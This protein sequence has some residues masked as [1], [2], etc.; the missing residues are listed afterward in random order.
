MG[1]TTE[2]SGS[3]Y[4]KNGKTIDEKTI[5]LLRAFDHNSHDYAQVKKE[6]Q[7][8]LTE[9]KSNGTLDPNEPYEENHDGYNQWT[10]QN[11]RYFGREFQSIRWD[12]VEKFYG[13]VAWLEHIIKY[14]FAPSGYIIEGNVKYFGEDDYDMGFIKVEN[15]V[16][17][18]V[19][20]QFE[21]V[22]TTNL[23]WC[24]R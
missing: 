23:G 24:A 10:I 13:Y 18:H 5:R 15:N 7:I 9:M 21:G 19:Q 3:F 12:G 14:L 8:F 22:D 20:A 1:Y 6:F 17:K 2:F 11:L 4:V 16:V